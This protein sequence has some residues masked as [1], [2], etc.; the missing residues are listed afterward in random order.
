MFSSA[1]FLLHLKG[2]LAGTPLILES[3]PKEYR[4][5]INAGTLVSWTTIIALMSPIAYAMRNYSWHVLQ[6]TYALC[7]VWSIIQW[8]YLYYFLSNIHTQCTQCTLEKNPY[9]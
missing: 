1:N 9:T 2:L 3:V 7:D 8:W 4:H 6:L 5:Y